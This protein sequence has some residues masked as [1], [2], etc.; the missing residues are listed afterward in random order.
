L[1]KQRI[2]KI[3]AV[4]LI[5]SLIIAD[6]V[7]PLRFINNI[8]D[9][10]KVAEGSKQS[11]DFK[12]PDAISTDFD[13]SAIKLNNKPLTINTIKEGKSNLEFY[14][15]GLFPLKKV[16]LDVVPDVYVRPG[17]QPI[18]VKVKTRGTMVV[19]LSEVIGCDARV[20]KPARKAG[21]QPGD[22]ILTLDN[23]KVNCA[24]D[25]T[26][27]LNKAGNKTIPISVKRDGGILKKQ[28]MPIKSKEDSEFRIGLWVKDHTA[29]IG[30]LTFTT[31]DNKMFGALGHAITDT[32]TGKKLSLSDGEI[33]NTEIT[34]I[35]SG[36]SNKPGEIRG[37]F[38]NELNPQGSIEENTSFG[39]FGHMN[40]QVQGKLMPI[41]LQ[42]EIK[43]GPAQ[44]LIDL[45][46][47][48]TKSYDVEIIKTS[49]QSRPSS[50]SMVIKVTDRR[51]LKK[52]GG[53]IQGMSGSP[54]IQ[55]GKLIGAVTHVFVNDPTRGYGVYIEWMFNQIE[56][57]EYK[58]VSG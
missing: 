20:Y 27:I 19:G 54:I 41:G 2:S 37:V 21:I 42:S 6:Y 25:I 10:I 17:G 51:L 49:D 58:T 30:T 22:M 3:F 14:L 11:F 4:F 34:S 31:E 35:E 7:F 28:I 57:A 26:R 50:K 53:I 12:L 36:K 23:V 55:N 33:Y 24:D 43:T 56:P 44:I 13:T 16:T 45:D 46:N 39:I 40:K 1:D 8:P 15:F 5:F 48:G 52:T 38:T 29:G 47:K 18:G 9:V 32:A